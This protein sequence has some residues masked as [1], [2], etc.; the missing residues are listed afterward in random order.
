MDIVTVI[1]QALSLIGDRVYK[2]GSATSAPL[3]LHYNSVVRRCLLKHDWS[4]AR[5]LDKEVKA[6]HRHIHK[7]H[8]GHHEKHDEEK[9]RHELAEK[10]NRMNRSWIEDDVYYLLPAD[11]LVVRDLKDSVSGRRL[12]EFQVG[13]DTQ[14]YNR[15]VRSEELAG[16]PLLVTYTSNLMSLGG[17]LPDV[18]GGF[19]DGVVYTLA[20][21]I[22]PVL[23]VD[24]QMASYLRAEGE[25]ILGEARVID[26]RQD[27]SNDQH[28]LKEILGNDILRR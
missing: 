2:E 11:C 13:V 19:I 4:F 26:A 28:P 17:E 6:T 25:R 12:K 15:I 9:P 8:G 14:T 5:V 1:N 27:A 3:K 7:E 22:S 18:A 23:G 24:L 20:A 16:A 21:A 10:M